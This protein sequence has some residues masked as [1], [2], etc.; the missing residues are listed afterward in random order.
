MTTEQRVCPTCGSHKFGSHQLPDGT[1]QR[2]CHGY[3]AAGPPCTHQWHESE[4]EKNGVNTAHI[5]TTGVAQ[6]V[7]RG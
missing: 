2:M 3:T 1:M 7:P 6:E 5:G 4:D